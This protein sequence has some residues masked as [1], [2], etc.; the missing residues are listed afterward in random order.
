MAAAPTDAYWRRSSSWA[1]TDHGISS[2]SRINQ[3]V[4]EL[5]PEVGRGRSR[6][7]DACQELA[8]RVAVGEERS[9]G[10]RVDHAG[11]RRLL[12]AEASAATSASRHT[13]DDGTRAHVL[14]LAHDVPHA[15]APEVGERLRGMFEQALA[16]RSS[17]AAP[18]S[19]ADR[20]ASVVRPRSGSSPR[21]R[22]RSSPRGS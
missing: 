1:L 21:A 8:P 9:A 10:A 3:S 2:Q 5:V 16:A 7:A 13:T 11:R 19:A 20:R 22:R 14:L 12:D 17:P 6:R 15:V 4:V 18:W